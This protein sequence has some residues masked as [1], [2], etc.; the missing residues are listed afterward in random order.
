[1][2]GSRPSAA[3]ISLLNYPGI[4]IHVFC[5]LGICNNIITLKLQVKFF[6]EQQFAVVDGVQNFLLFS[7]PIQC[8]TC[9]MW[10]TRSK[11]LYLNENISWLW[12]NETKACSFNTLLLRKIGIDRSILLAYVW[13]PPQN[14]LAFQ[15][16]ENT[17]SHAVYDT[18]ICVP[19]L[20][21]WRSS[22]TG[23]NVYKQLPWVGRYCCQKWKSTIRWFFLKYN[24]YILVS[25]LIWQTFVLLLALLTGHL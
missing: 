4:N 16:L 22:K 12:R 18:E 23:I 15:K 1:M 20:H 10:T 21:S 19:M 3:F 8:K 24:L 7:H 5:L 25:C 17:P 14:I 2:D 9:W 11:E 6:L 13:K